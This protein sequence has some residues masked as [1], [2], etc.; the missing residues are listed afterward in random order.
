MVKIIIILLAL[1][2][3][4]NQST[5]FETAKITLDFENIAVYT[6]NELDANE[7]ILTERNGKLIIEIVYGEVISEDKDGRILNTNN[8]D[9]DY[10]SYRNI[11]NI[12]VGDK[13][14]T[15]L[16]YSPI[17]NFTDDIIFRYDFKFEIKKG[18][19]IYNNENG[20]YIEFD[21]ETFWNLE[22][23]N[24]FID[25]ETG[26]KIQAVIINYQIIKINKI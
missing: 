19:I 24:N 12:E 14:I 23:D 15:I 22:P 9:F 6:L 2:L 26:A 18:E 11:D 7:K 5:G 20:C 10:I 17:T 13:I 8:K 25:Y 4:C 3:F 16:A 1:N 21:D